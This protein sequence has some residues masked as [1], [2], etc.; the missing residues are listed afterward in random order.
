V[1][2]HSREAKTTEQHH[3]SVEDDRFGEVLDRIRAEEKTRERR[4]YEP[5]GSKSE[6][7]TAV[8]A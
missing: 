7:L 4:S 1:Q 8:G 5:D 2:A 6:D 3:R